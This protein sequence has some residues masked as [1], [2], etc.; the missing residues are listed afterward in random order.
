MS[1]SN[2]RPTQFR[3][4][5]ALPAGKEGDIRQ[6]ADRVVSSVT[7]VRD[8]FTRTSLRKSGTTNSSLKV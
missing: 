5:P 3:W 6:Q 1:T 2:V 7:Q 8:F 4:Y